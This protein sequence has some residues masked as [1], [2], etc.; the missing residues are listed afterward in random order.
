MTT[1]AQ[2]SNVT[3]NGHTLHCQQLFC[4]TCSTSLQG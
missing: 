4:P 1:K 3:D 2:I